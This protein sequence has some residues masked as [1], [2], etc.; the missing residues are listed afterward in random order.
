[1]ASHNDLGVKGENLAVEY[2]LNE[3]Y[4]IL[5]RNWRY[6][7][8]EIDV[9]A[10]KNDVLAIVEV[11]TRSSNAFVAPEDA[12]NKKKIK[13]LVMAADAFI[14]QNDLDVEARF[15]IISVYKNGE[16]YKIHHKIDAFFV[17]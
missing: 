11:K 15:D 8:A 2:L 5:E 9:L 3:G 12:V 13:L 6:Q 10:R 16:K 4:T 1:M 17:F 14:T 7:R